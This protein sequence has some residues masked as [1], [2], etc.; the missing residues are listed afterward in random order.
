MSAECVLN[1]L[2]EQGHF[3]VG[4]D[5]YPKEWHYE[6]GLCDVFYQAPL[7]IHEDKYREFLLDVAIRHS[8]HYI[9][10][11]TDLEIDVI[12]RKRE[13]FEEKGVILCMQTN[14]VLKTVRNKYELYKVFCHDKRVPSIKTF[15]LNEIPDGIVFPCIAKPYNGRSSEGLMHINNKDQLAAISDKD[16]YILQEEIPGNVYTVDYCRSGLYGT[17]VAIP[18][19]ELLRTKNGAGLTIQTISDEKLI[20]LCSY[21]GRKLDINGCVNMEF[22]LNKENYYLIDINPRFSAGVAFSILMN[23]DM[24]N[25]HL[26]CF[27]NKDIDKQINIVEKIIVKKYQEVEIH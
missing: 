26:R 25:N 12:S 20:Q 5:I 15:L 22:I 8:I 24:I 16:K 18:R 6:S 27:Q 10:P 9:I 1:K 3:L 23:Y 2:K 21:I 4:C 19:K 13:M 14:N 11:L 7:S 17:D